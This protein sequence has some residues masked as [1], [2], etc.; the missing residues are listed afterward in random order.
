[1]PIEN[2]NIGFDAG[3]FAHR[4]HTLVTKPRIQRYLVRAESR[5]E[6]RQGRAEKSA[7]RDHNQ[8]S[9]REFEQCQKRSD[10]PLAG[11]QTRLTAL[12]ARSAAEPGLASCIRNIS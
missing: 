6:A 12:Q 3:S 10:I 11:M 9:C 4:H 2:E 7:K 1:M 8:G 5:G